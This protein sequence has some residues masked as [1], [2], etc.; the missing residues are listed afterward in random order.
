MLIRKENIMNNKKRGNILY[1]I[2][3]LLLLVAVIFVVV[4]KD[5][6]NLNTTVPNKASVNT[7]PVKTT[8]SSLDKYRQDPVPEDCRLAD[9]DNDVKAWAE[10]LSHHGNTKYCL[11]YYEGLY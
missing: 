10:H 3:V 5:T 7:A 8:D 9:Y 11:E 6:Q 1:G 2:V 4:S